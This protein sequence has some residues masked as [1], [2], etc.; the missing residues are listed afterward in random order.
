LDVTKISE[1]LTLGTAMNVQLGYVTKSGYAADVRYSST[2]P[3]FDENANSVLQEQTAMT[4]G[5]SKYMKGNA[6]KL[7]TTVNQ[8]PIPWA[9]KIFKL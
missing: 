5:L 4:L 1:Y 7:Q 9:M 6:L 3:E 2:T 8:L